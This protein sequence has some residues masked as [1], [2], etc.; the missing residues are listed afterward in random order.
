MRDGPGASRCSSN[1]GFAS[2][3]D[4]WD[5]LELALREGPPHHQRRPPG[6]RLVVAHRRRRPSR[7]LRNRPDDV[8]LAA[9]RRPAGRD[10]GRALVGSSV[11]RSSALRAP[12]QRVR[13]PAFPYCWT[14]GRADPAL[15]PLG[16]ASLASARCSSPR[17]ATESAP[18]DRFP[19]A[20]KTLDRVCRSFVDATR[21][22]RSTVPGTSRAA[23]RR[24]AGPRF[25]Q[26]Q[27]RYCTAAAAALLL[28][29]RHRP[30]LRWRASASGSPTSCRTPAT[31]G[32]R[33]AGLTSRWW[34][35]R[36][37]PPARA[38]ASSKERAALSVAACLVTDGLRAGASDHARGAGD[39]HRASEAERHAGVTPIAE[40]PRDTA[41]DADQ[42]IRISGSCT[43]GDF[44]N[45]WDLGRGPTPS[46]R[47][48]AHALHHGAA[49]NTQ[50]NAD[51]RLPP[52]RRHRRGLGSLH[53][54]PHPRLDNLRLGS[55]P[56][57]DFRYGGVNRVAPD[58]PLDLVAALRAGAAAVRRAHR[59][60]MGAL[61]RPGTGFFQ[62]GQRIDD[63]RATSATASPLTTPLAGLLWTAAYEITS[64]E[65][66]LDVVR[67]E[68]RPLRPDPKDDEHRRLRRLPL[69]PS[70]SPPAS[71][72]PRAD[73]LQPRSVGSHRRQS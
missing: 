23:P 25:R 19:A 71:A 44:H 73:H 3:H 8:V 57:G 39:E 33:R 13:Q 35:P 66:G 5:L 28:R 63:D 69:G 58:R 4:V 22:S 64:A 20:L 38:G 37:H 53:P 40:P 2:N 29:W 24:R 45:N 46:M 50:T 10:V 42:R 16:C 68:I 65:P 61:C 14:A 18:A 49:A 51:M 9:S 7:S 30:R 1:H 36:R 15:L 6:L 56:D 26:S 17:T 59:G 60:R 70:P 31:S 21:A 62:R 67:P 48:L 52:R 47:P 27:S 55:T 54:R 34:R 11:A 41:G 32:F 12:P 43:R 72:S